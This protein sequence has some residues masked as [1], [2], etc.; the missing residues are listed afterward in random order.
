[1]AEKSSKSF[2][3]SSPIDGK[4]LKTLQL[5][6]GDEIHELFRRNCVDS[7]P[8]SREESLAFLKRLCSSIKKNREILIPMMVN[9][10]GYI[11]SDSAEIID[12]SIDFLDQFENEVAQEPYRPGMTAR[13]FGADTERKIH[14]SS[15]PYRQ[16][17][18]II[19]QNASFGTAL[20]V[21]AA[22]L[23]SGSKLVLRASLQ[24]GL[25]NDLLKKMVME[26]APPGN[27]VEFVNC[28]ATDFLKACYESPQVD[29][30]HYIGSNRYVASV[31]MDSF[32]SGKTCLLDGQGNGLAYIDQSFPI[33]KAVK[34]VAEGAVRYNGET[35]TSI[36]GVICH[37]EIYKDFRDGLAKAL[38]SLT[39]GNPMETDT[40]VGPLFS[41][42]QTAHIGELVRSSGGKFLS[43]GTIKGSYIEPGL[44]EGVDQDKSLVTEGFM[45]PIVWLAKAAFRESDAWFGKN[46]YPL[47]DTILSLDSD[48]I[49]SFVTRSRSPRV[50]IN[51]D[52]SLESMFEPWGGYPPSGLNPVSIWTQKYLQTF[53]IDGDEKF[54]KLLG[55]ESDKLRA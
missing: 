47:S 4:H 49:R 55:L 31:L 22:A 36:N 11:L 48:Q 17:A 5:L 44:V 39:W 20:I 37:P 14:I 25:T 18:A 30:I 52:S 50:C 26:S 2:S 33:D 51:V 32:K 8:N 21:L 24:A 35:C 15:R 23:Y 1:M 9:E 3:V 41:E 42:T 7:V 40:D 19:P 13:S 6:S 53:Q 43:G 12:G 27:S 29:L 28:L 38:G 54:T 16:V 45:G 46:Q 34:I 10:T